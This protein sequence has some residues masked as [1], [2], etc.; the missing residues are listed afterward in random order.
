MKP[1]LRAT[2]NVH[3]GSNQA[4]FE[5]I[6]IFVLQED[7]TIIYYSPV[8]D[9]SGYGNNEIEAKDSLEVSIEEFFRYTMNKKTL[10]SELSKL[11]WTKVKRKKKFTPPAMTDMIKKHPYLSEIINEHDF[12]KQTMPV[13]IPA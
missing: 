13:A 8:F 5:N 10:E 7:K 11:G 1:Q 3:S 2:G 6:P 9:L 4:N 12:R